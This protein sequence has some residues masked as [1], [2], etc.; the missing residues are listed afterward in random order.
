MTLLITNSLH[1]E[2]IKLMDFPLNDGSN[3]SYTINSD[4][5]CS[6]KNVRKINHSSTDLDVDGFTNKVNRLQRDVNLEPDN[7]IIQKELI[8]FNLKGADNIRF[9]FE[10]EE[11]SCKL[12][13]I[14]VKDE[15]K[16]SF[17]SFDVNYFNTLGSP[18]LRKLTINESAGKKEILY[19]WA[20]HSHYPTYEL[21]GGLGVEVHS[22]YRLRDQRSFHKSDPAVGPVGI[23]SFRYGPLFIN[24]TGAG[25]L[26]FSYEDLSLLALGVLEG[27]N[28][29]GGNLKKRREGVFLGNI[30]SWKFIDFTWYNDFFDT[31]GLQYKLIFAPKFYYKSDWRFKPQ[32]FAQ[33]WSAKYV[34]YY[35]GVTPEESAASGLAT[36]KGKSTM[37]YGSAV[38]IMHYIGRW[39]VVGEAQAKFFGNKVYNSPTTTK[40]EELRFTTGL[41]YKF[42]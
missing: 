9:V 16:K 28:Y 5:K 19:P 26:L 39:T 42:F 31:K 18:V 14:F 11:G 15:E 36:Y 23:F 13:K 22:N 30:L 12:Q 21:E 34:D 40:G 35:Y 38:E 41:L 17:T 27:E 3:F 6:F 20:L 1:A 7:V 33:Y 2:V 4:E 24:K 25:T 29:T 32:V 8:S 37:N 10:M